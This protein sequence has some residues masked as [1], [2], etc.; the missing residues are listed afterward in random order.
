MDHTI[1]APYN[2]VPFSSVV[3]PLKEQ[4][5]AHN[6]LDSQ[7]KTG[8]LH[9]T[10]TAHTPV[11]V[12]D[13]MKDSQGELHFFRNTQGNYVLPASTLR[14]MVRNNMKILSFSYFRPKEDMEDIQIYFRSVAE[15]GGSSREDVKKYYK[16]ALGV[17]TKK[18]PKGKTY[19]RPMKVETGYLCCRGDNY[20][21]LPTKGSYL[22][23]SRNDPHVKQFEGLSGQ[24]TKRPDDA[25]IIPVSYRE[26]QG[27]VKGIW[28]QKS[29]EKSGVLLY[30]GKGVRQANPIYLFPEMDEQGEPIP[31]SRE[32]VLSYRED[33][34]Q[35]CNTLKKRYDKAFWQLPEEGEHKPVFFLRYENHTYFGMALFLRIGYR[36]PLSHGL[37]S[38]HKQEEQAEHRTL[39]YTDSLLG[40]ATKQEAYRS[41]VLFEDCKVQ[42]TV[43]EMGATSMILLGPKPS[44]YPS[45]AMPGESGNAVHYSQET[46]KLRGYKQYW[47]K[48]PEQPKV[49][50]EKNQNSKE[51]TDSKI[52]VIHP[53]PKNTVFRGVI[54]YQNLTQEELGLLIWCLKL[55]PD[56]FQS[57]GMGKPYGYGCM[58][59][60]IEKLVE[61]DVAELYGETLFPEPKLSDENQ[62]QQYVH[63]FDKMAVEWLKEEKKAY[64]RCKSI[65]DT[66]EIQD[67]FF[68]KQQ[69]E[70]IDCRYMALESYKNPIGALPTVRM[71][72]KEQDEKQK[73][74]EQQSETMEEKLK[75]L[76]ATK[77]GIGRS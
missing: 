7:R 71:F 17:V 3:L 26:E 59:L 1:H 9:I 37:Y 8:E 11:F 47:F 36:Y 20:Y 6:R 42:G 60:D 75:R 52:M 21:I 45:Y 38:V 63:S 58:K 50:D 55:E 18:S 4:P 31:I 70:W 15:K 51:E 39:D 35:R 57:I 16:T 23:I 30:T 22:R 72:R 33:W 77:R 19:A 53:L 73:Q 48:K 29:G 28:S 56:C 66:P 62:I 61:Y 65:C 24:K 49:K 27:V 64:R 46:F 41:R 32:D 74:Q 69:H 68:M 14:G 34:E 44:F 12:S 76:Q 54:H 67:F 2:F 5:P 40:Y 43:K 25:R 10:L 13:G